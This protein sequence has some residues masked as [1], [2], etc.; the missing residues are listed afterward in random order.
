MPDRAATFARSL[1]LKSGGAFAEIVD[2][3]EEGEA[4]DQPLV[5]IVEPRGAC[6]PPPDRRLAKQ[7]F[8]NASHV[9][10]VIDQRVPGRPTALAVAEFPPKIIRTGSTVH[11]QRLPRRERPPLEVDGRPS[12]ATPAPCFIQPS[13]SLPTSCPKGTT[14]A[15][16]QFAEG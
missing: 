8:Q 2:E 12:S 16:V 10:A 15:I 14:L 7:R 3:G 13:A 4:R 6:Q 11:G 9:D 1:G 5:D